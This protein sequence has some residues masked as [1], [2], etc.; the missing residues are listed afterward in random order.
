LALATDYG[1]TIAPD[2]KVDPC[3]LDALRRVKDTG[4]RLLLV[5]GREIRHLKQA[6]PEFEL[7][8]RIVGENGALYSTHKPVTPSKAGV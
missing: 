8:D 5:T 2:G 7:F 4:R 3:T 1:G 6:F